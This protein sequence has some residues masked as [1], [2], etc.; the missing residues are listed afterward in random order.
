M[1]ITP[2]PRGPSVHVSMSSSPAPKGFGGHFLGTE[3]TPK[4]RGDPVSMFLYCCPSAQGASA[5]PL[6]YRRDPH[7]PTARGP[8]CPRPQCQGDLC[9]TTGGQN[10][11]RC[12]VPISLF[13]G[14]KETSLS[15]SSGYRKDAPCILIPLTKGPRR[16]CPGAPILSAEGSP[17]SLLVH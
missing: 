13:P 7:I 15:L 14:G 2:W 17:V 4:D 10:G 6:G 8:M 11:S 5:S 16:P 1:S 9:V 12:Y 3:C